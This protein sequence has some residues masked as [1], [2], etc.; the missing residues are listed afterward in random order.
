MLICP[1]HDIDGAKE[2]LPE[3]VH[4]IKELIKEQPFNNKDTSVHI[5]F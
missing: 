2:G 1:A 3:K 4:A 5:K